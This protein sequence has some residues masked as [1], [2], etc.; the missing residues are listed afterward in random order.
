MATDTSSR[1]ARMRPAGPLDG[2]E[3]MPLFEAATVPVAADAA[4]PG[5]IVTRAV[6]GSF[7]NGILT[8][9]G[10]SQDNAV[11]VS[12][13]AAGQILSNVPVAG[14]PTVANTSLIQV[15][16]QGGNDVITLDESNGALPRANL[17]GGAGNDTI[18]GGS[19][20]D[21]LFGQSGNDVLLGKGGVDFLFGGDGDDVLT[22]GDADDQMF[23]EAGNDRIIWNPGD[24]TDLAEGGSGTDT[25]EVNG[26]NGAENFALTTNG[27]RLR[28]DRLDP[29]P[30]SIDA[31]TME[32]VVINANGGDDVVNASA[33]AA[34]SATL[35][36]DGGT[37]NDTI[38]GSRGADLLLGGDGNDLVTGG[39]GNDVALLGA[40]DDGFVWNPGDDNDVVEGQDGV[41]RLIFNGANIGESMDISANGGR[42]R[43]FR[44]V[45]AVTMDLD[46][47]ERID[48]A[49]LGGADKFQVGDLSG[50][51][52]TQVNINL[53]G[54]LG[55]ST[56]DGQVDQVTIAATNGNDAVDV[57]GAGASLIVTGLAAAVSLFNVDAGTDALLLNMGAGNDV[58]SA[59]T[60]PAGSVK[61]TIDGGAGNDTIT[62]GQG[63]DVL[64]GGD[65]NDLVIG[66][67]GDDIALLGAGD[68]DFVWNPGDD[69]DVVEG[70]AGFDRL[71][72]NGANI[73]ET[74]SI[75]AVGERARLFR[76]VAAVTMDLNDVERIDIAALGG[77][78]QFQ[79]GDL[80]GTD[81]KLV[82]IALAGVLGGA[83]GD[84]AADKVTVSG[85]AGI[86]QID[87]DALGTQASVTG[88]AATTIL[89]E[90]EGAND[91]L[92]I[93]A[94]AG[95]DVIDASGVAAGAI[96]LVVEAG[97]GNDIILG[98]AGGD[99]VL[100]GD[101][102]DIAL[103]GAGD[104]T[105]VWNPG[106]DNDVVEGQAGFDTLVFN[107]ANVNETI[108]L[109]ANGGRVLLFRDIA[110]VTM[111]LNDVE[112]T[113]VATLGGA[114]TVTVG[115][116][117]G[118]DLAKLTIDLAGTPGSTV[119]DGARDTVVINA[120][121]G[122]DAITLSLVNGDLV[123]DGLATQVV[124]AHFDLNDT[125]QILGLGGEDVIDASGL[126]ANGPSLVIDGGAGNDLMFGGG[127]ADVVLGG[128]GDDVVLGGGGADVLL[129]G[130]GA[131]VL[132]GQA[133]DDVLDGGIGDDVLIGGLGSDILLSGGGTDI[134]IN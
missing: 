115:D 18:T 111:D 21:Q 46:D 118:T 69:N 87:V 12:R 30:F 53:A 125:I 124:I 76:D 16:G 52:V 24:D 92:V 75:S 17:F 72:F 126:G 44:D 79:V 121:N 71:I 129:G 63:A 73:G 113:R 3:A 122:D 93:A 29:A 15:F 49:A 33:L 20:G 22:G 128:D 59:A 61:L 108:N 131:D 107:G 67:D 4:A 58:I 45:A 32:K 91:Q 84:G 109:S 110:A 78:D 85:T 8:L 81:V 96:R 94:G 114:D 104:D 74:M 11:T 43:L 57:V 95:A 77:A 2:P 62:G 13:N 38:T 134:F 65:G 48:I 47:V 10:D 14:A 80:S 40:G 28:A 100:G 68:D 51:D 36:I 105:F 132:D 64:L 89:A 133:G 120:T 35:T 1:Q 103:M 106:D 9:L 19:G 41:D 31:G 25:L 116:L 26:G 127:G 42:A 82:R 99:L 119:G 7:A 39:D 56:A 97:A 101:G 27:T 86:D 130:I 55:G 6:T 60:L 66:D 70:Q 123:V 34:A 117:S 112:A 54:T 90:A 98:G 37:G 88:L 5:G 102:N 23:G 50:T 83:A